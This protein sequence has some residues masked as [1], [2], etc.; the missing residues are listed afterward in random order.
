MQFMFCNVY[1]RSVYHIRVN[2]LVGLFLTLKKLLLNA[3]MCMPCSLAVLL[4][5]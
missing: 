4:L 1:L 3:Y 5:Y 2:F